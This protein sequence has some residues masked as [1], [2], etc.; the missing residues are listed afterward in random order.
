MKII[1]IG[2]VVYLGDIKKTDEGVSVENALCLGKSVNVGKGH[3][4]EYVKTKQIGKLL[5]S[6]L[7]RG[8]GSTFTE[9]DLDE[10]MQTELQILGVRMA[11]AVKLA[12]PELINKKFS[13]LIGSDYVVAPVVEHTH[14]HT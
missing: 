3:L 1:T 10:D 13:S 6:I 2:S 4:A 14:R 11:Q 7:V 5:P 12:V 9:C 8:T